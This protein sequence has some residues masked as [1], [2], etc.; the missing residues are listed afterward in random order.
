M[1]RDRVQRK[2]RVRT[3]FARAGLNV[4]NTNDVSCARGR[5]NTKRPGD[6]SSGRDS[7]RWIISLT[8]SPAVKAET[9]FVRRSNETISGRPT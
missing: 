9:E 3:E 4:P 1:E 5:K 2:V 7:P 8:N 6:N